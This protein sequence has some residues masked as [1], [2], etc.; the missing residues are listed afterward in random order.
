MIELLDL[1]DATGSPAGSSPA[2]APTSCGPG[3]R[4]VFGIPP[5]RIIGSS[6][7]VT[8]QIGDAG[9]EL[10]KGTDLA[11]LDDKDRRS[12]SRSTSRV[13]QRPI[14]AAGNTDGDLPM[15][16]WTAA[17]PH[18][19]LELVVHHTDAEREFAYAPRLPRSP[20]S[21]SGAALPLGERQVLHDGRVG[22]RLPERGARSRSDR[23]RRP[24]TARCS[25]RIPA[26]RRRHR[27]C[28]CT[29]E[30]RSRTRRSSRAR[31][32]SASVP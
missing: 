28:A 14:F 22:G 16:Q 11:V 27:G 26:A 30:P 25:R 3:P 31:G 29:P 19:T 24:G 15:L 20:R 12:R 17:S 7:S 23:P 8:F 2:A 4:E 10:L 6:G 13:G 18:R 1:L 9:P 32:S 5:H 21:G